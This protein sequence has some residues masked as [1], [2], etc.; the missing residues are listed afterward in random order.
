M[1]DGVS[2]SVG[3]I[4]FLLGLGGGRV[5]ID[6]QSLG[7]PPVKDGRVTVSQTWLAIWSLSVLITIRWI[8]NDGM[9][10]LF[11]SLSS[12]SSNSPRRRRSFLTPG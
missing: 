2:V 11:V 10:L 8:Q 5:H 6:S 7:H 3:V 1:S 4:D 9:V 12:F